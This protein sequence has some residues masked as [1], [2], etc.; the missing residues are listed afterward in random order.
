M[1]A[2]QLLI[3]TNVDLILLD[4]EMPVVKGPQI[5]EMIRSEE[6]M[7]DIPI[8]PR[9]IRTGPAKIQGLYPVFSTLLPAMA[10]VMAIPMIMHSM[11]SP[12]LMALYPSTFCRNIDVNSSSP[13]IE[14]PSRNSNK[15]A[16][17]TVGFFSTWG[18]MMGS[19]ALDSTLLS[20][21]M[22]PTMTKIIASDSIL[23]TS[24]A[25]PNNWK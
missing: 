3:R 7:K 20:R 5:F 10:E 4:Y 11:K 12:A 9:A 1:N 25:V 13:I 14:N 16:D 22:M 21:M 8:I 17:L 15:D 19:V 6:Q 2:I 24:N 23:M 18:A